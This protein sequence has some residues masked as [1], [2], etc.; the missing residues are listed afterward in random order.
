MK[1]I[2]TKTKIFKNGAHT[3]FEQS[4]ISG[5][6]VVKLYRANG[7]IA[8]NVICDKYIHAKHYFKCFNAIAKTI[9]P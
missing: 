9:H 4:K 8:D 7:D 2:E 5:L 1:N 3:L 6:F